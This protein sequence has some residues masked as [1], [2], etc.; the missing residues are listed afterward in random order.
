MTGGYRNVINLRKVTFCSFYMIINISLSLNLTTDF[1]LSNVLEWFTGYG[2]D[3]GFGANNIDSGKSGEEN[4][5]DKFIEKKVPGYGSNTI[6]EEL[7]KQDSYKVFENWAK[8]G[9]FPNQP[10]PHQ[11]DRVCKQ[12]EKMECR[13]TFVLELHTSMGKVSIA[14]IHLNFVIEKIYKQTDSSI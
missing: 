12:G 11:C 5:I 2:I 3:V 6:E 13:Y 1:S 14:K 4:V 10:E 9:D 7:S 8:K